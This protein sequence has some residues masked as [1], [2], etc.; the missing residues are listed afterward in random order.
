[1]RSRS[2]TALDRKDMQ[3]A[4]SAGDGRRGNPKTVSPILRFLSILHSSLLFH[5]RR[6]A[7]QLLM[8]QRETRTM[9]SRSW[10]ALDRK[11]MQCALS[12]GD[13]RRGNHGFFADSPVLTA[14]KTAT[15]D[16]GLTLARFASQ[17]EQAFMALL[18]GLGSQRYAVRTVCW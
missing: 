6:A 17:Q 14:R 1:M 10:T 11:D 13:G 2:W 7:K 16:P 9:R 18:D 12:A 5:L 3:C 4:L 15:P 8:R